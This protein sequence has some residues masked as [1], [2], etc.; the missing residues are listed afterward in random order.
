M[1]YSHNQNIAKLMVFISICDQ[2]MYNNLREKEMKNFYML[3]VL[4]TDYYTCN[5][6]RLCYSPSFYFF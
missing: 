1:F 4:P 2:L 3:G 5:A 6:Q